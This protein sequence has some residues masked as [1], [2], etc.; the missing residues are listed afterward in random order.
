MPLSCQPLPGAPQV[1]NT[2]YHP[3]S[4]MLQPRYRD[5]EYHTELAA[6]R[7]LRQSQN[8]FAVVEGPVLILPNDPSE[9]CKWIS[10]QPAKIHFQL[11]N[12]EQLVGNEDGEIPVK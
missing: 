3:T 2:T 11:L 1:G 8:K 10:L 6:S 7:W 5:Y 9:S 4:G 12:R